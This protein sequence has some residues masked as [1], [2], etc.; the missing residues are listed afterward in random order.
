MNRTQMNKARMQKA[1]R[2]GVTPLDMARMHEIARKEA[3]KIETEYLEK[4]FLFMLAIP[5]NVLV[6]DYWPKSAR[7]KAPKFIEDVASLFESVQNGTVSE[8]ELADLLN[9][10]AGVNITAEWMK[11]KEG[12]KNVSATD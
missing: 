8:Q 11:T 6:N 2:A 5:L 1:K 3:R 9:E 12:R 7:Q 4:A 10:M